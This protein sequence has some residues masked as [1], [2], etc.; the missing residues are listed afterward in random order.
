MSM[1]KVS[2]RF[3]MPKDNESDNNKREQQINEWFKEVIEK[4]KLE[5]CQ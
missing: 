3:I 5:D 1:S 2:K 4:E